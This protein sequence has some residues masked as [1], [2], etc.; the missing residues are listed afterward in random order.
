MRV[1]P[2]LIEQDVITQEKSII[3]RGPPISIIRDVKPNS[4]GGIGRLGH[5]ETIEGHTP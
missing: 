4:I 1:K 3:S 2:S 5:K